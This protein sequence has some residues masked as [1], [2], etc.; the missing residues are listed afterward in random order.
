MIELSLRQ[1]HYLERAVTY[2]LVIGM[3]ALLMIPMIWGALSTVRPSK[4]LFTWP[5]KIIP[6]SVTLENYRLLLETTSFVQYFINSLTTAIL[7]MI[8]TL[9]I[10]IPAAYAVTRYEFHGRKYVSNLSTIIYM[11]PLVLLGLPLFV[12]FSRLSL[13]NSRIGLALTHTA[14]ALPFALML[15]RVFFNDISPAIVESA[16]LVGASRLTIIR[17][18]ILPLSLPGI[19]A[20]II[21]VMALSWKEYFFALLMMNDSGLYTLPI[22]IANLINIATTNWGLILSGVMIMSLPPM[23]LIFFLYDYLLEGF[24][25]SSL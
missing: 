7:A 16:R 22:G 5:P 21:F 9:A 10:A 13:T 1:R 14:F 19:V 15:L 18:I 6:S 4:D 11:F 8:F 23:L 12:I 24:S 25:V 2:G 17:K 3:T 20:T